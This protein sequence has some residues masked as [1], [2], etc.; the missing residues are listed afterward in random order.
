[1]T[2][3]VIT[4]V[5]IVALLSLASLEQAFIS[6]TYSKLKS[7]TIALQAAI[8]GIPESEGINTPENIAKINGMYAYWLKKEHK[9]AMLARHTDLSFISDAI[10]YVKNFVF[11]DNKEEACV[12]LEKLKY[13]LD[14][15]AFN[16]GTSIQNVI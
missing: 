7:D 14:T 4:F 15:H 13:L 12:G 6:N 2:R 9:L 11:F 10:I 5:L 8:Y 3:L 16:V 1:M